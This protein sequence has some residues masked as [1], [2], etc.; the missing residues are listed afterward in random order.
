M[1]E[2]NILFLSAV[3]WI[4]WWK[5]HV[6]VR[7]DKMIGYSFCCTDIWDYSAAAR[8]KYGMIMFRV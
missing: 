8:V 4:Q 2:R 3:L 1:P 6:L 5:T 7:K